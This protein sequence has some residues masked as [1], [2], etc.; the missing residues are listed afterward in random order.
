MNPKQK[1]ELYFRKSQKA[2]SHPIIKEFFKNEKNKQLLEEVIA[3]PTNENTCLLDNRFK[4]YY[5]RARIVKYVSTLI[6]NYSIEYDKKDRKRRKRYQLTLDNTN[7]MES[8][9]ESVYNHEFQSLYSSLPDQ[10]ENEI[11]YNALNK[12]SKKQLKILE[13]IYIYNFSNKEVANCFNESAQ[14]I[15]SLHKKSLKRLKLIISN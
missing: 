14:N 10:I 5:Q 13:L 12:L 4:S 11:L 9:Y 15:S 8:N 3:N 2:F 7:F 1:V 6:H